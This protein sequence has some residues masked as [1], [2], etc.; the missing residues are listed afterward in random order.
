MLEVLPH[1]GRRRFDGINERRVRSFL[2][3]VRPELPEVSPQVVDFLLVLDAGKHH[4]GPGDLG[5]RVLDVILEDAL[6]PGDPGVLVALGVVEALGGAGL[7]AVEPV[8]FRPDLVLRALSDGMAREALLERLLAG[9]DILRRSRGRR[10]RQCD[11]RQNRS[12]HHASPFPWNDDAAGRPSRTAACEYSL[13]MTGAAT[14]VN[15]QLRRAAF[16]RG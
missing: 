3:A 12:S 5:A 8:E 14:P 4:L 10:G 9:G 7:A 2:L 16:R 11:C 1:A 15:V 13:R 6:V